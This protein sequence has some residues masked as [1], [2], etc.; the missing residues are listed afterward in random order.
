MDVLT[1]YVGQGA[2]AAVRSGD[3]AVVIDSHMPDCD[4]VTQ[5]QIETTL[6]DYLR[7]RKVRGLILTGLD[8]DH[9]HP[10]GVDSI[11]GR[12]EPDWVLYP[13][14]YKDT[15]TCGDVFSAVE[16]HERRRARTSHPLTRHSVRVDRLDSRL[17]RGLATYFSFELFSPHIEDMDNSNNSSIV[18]KL[19]GLDTTGFQYLVTGDTEGARWDSINRFYD[20]ALRADVMAAPHHGSVTGVSPA[21]LLLVEPDTVLISAG[22][23]NQFGHPHSA[24]VQAYQRIARHVFATNATPDGSCLFTRRIEGGYETRLVRHPALT[25]AG[26]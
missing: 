5:E 18:L 22:V 3:E 26:R 7:G 4:E 8:G 1:L 9:A 24:A 14:C 23:E 17:L 19:G 2:L 15:D 20:T 12:H 21:T 11:L 6:A 25:S 16:A 13:K 10:C